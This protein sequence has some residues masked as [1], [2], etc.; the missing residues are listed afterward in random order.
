MSEELVSIRGLIE[1]YQRSPL[2][3]FKGKLER[4][5]TELVDRFPPARTYVNLNYNDIEVIESVEPYPFPIA[6]LSFPLNKRKVSQWTVYADSLAKLIPENQD[7]RNTVNMIH[8][9]KLTSGHMMWNRDE[10]KATARE[11]WEVIGLAGE[12]A[13]QSSPMD[14]VARA[15]ELLDGKA[16]EEWNQLVFQ[17][18]VVKGDAKL[19]DNILHRVF[20]PEMES[21]GKISKDTNGIWHILTP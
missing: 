7:I 14:A 15:L 12:G 9:M 3:E 1:G 11:A 17:N 10:G 2:R 18:A 4:F 13:I 21:T 5:T 20:L 16:E 8:H 19:I 6:Q